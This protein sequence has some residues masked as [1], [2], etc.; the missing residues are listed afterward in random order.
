MD[1]TRIESLI[2]KM[3]EEVEAIRAKFQRDMQKVFKQAFM[4]FFDANPEVHCVY[5]RQ[6]TPYFNDGDECVFSCYASYAGVT[7][8][9]DYQSITYGEYDGED[10]GVWVDDPDY[11]D[12]N[13][14]LIPAHVSENASKLRSI[15]ERIDDSV[16][17]EMF[18]DH[19]MVY[20][21]RDGFEVT[22]YSHD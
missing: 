22:E 10:E 6:Y 11:G 4:E 14:E 18:G 13:S 20:A 16:F 9:K 15:L 3:N 19:C 2:D 1:T 21:T 5:W 7:N 8:A 12:F 17:K